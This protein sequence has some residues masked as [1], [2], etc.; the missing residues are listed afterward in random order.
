MSFTFRQAKRENEHLLIGMAGGTGSGKTYS[1]FRLAKGLSGG[2][3]F[4]VIDTE[5]GRAKHY[6]DEFD[7]DHGDLK[8]PFRP[9]AYAEA[10]KAADAAGYP[11]IVVDSASHE[12]AGDGGLLD[13]HEEEFQ[14]LG[15]R[16]TV[17][18][19][20]WIKPKQAHKRF[21]S[22]LLQIRAHLILCFRAEQKVE[23]V[24]DSQGKWQVVPKQSLTG[25]DGWIPISEKSL[26][27]E[28]TM[29]F[30][31]AG[32]APGLPRP[33]KLQAQHRELVP[34]DQQISED[35]G[36]ALAR[37]AGGASLNEGASA[38]D[39][40]EAESNGAAPS[41]SEG[42]EQY[43]S[44]LTVSLT[45]MLTRLGATAT[46]PRIAQH[47]AGNDAVKHATW[48]ETQIERAHEKLPRQDS[49]SA[50]DNSVESGSAAVA[51]PPGEP[52]RAD[53]EDNFFTQRLAEAEARKSNKERT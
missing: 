11:V 20:A 8:P 41:L 24:K 48:L 25:L 17:K 22:E 10:I 46:I 40:T 43:I 15:G 47:R 27:Y 50:V 13:W 51:L 3:K 28:L 42:A 38:G 30:L 5:A 12:H 7:F 18:M 52:E 21:V 39:P 32:D 16:D 29:S 4:A 14:R 33:I 6:A 36:Q 26:P 1:A 9:M 49:E 45:E 34:L 19:T 37:W 2:A 31:L 35:T 23:M 44:S 53:S